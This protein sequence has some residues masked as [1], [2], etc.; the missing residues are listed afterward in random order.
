M[1]QRAPASLR[2]SEAV[3]PRCNG[4]DV[5]EEVGVGQRVAVDGSVDDKFTT[6]DLSMT[7][8]G[9][10]FI[11]EVVGRCSS[12]GYRVTKPR[13]PG[14]TGRLASPCLQQPGRVERRERRDLVERRGHIADEIGLRQR[15]HTEPALARD[16][17][18]RCVGSHDARPVVEVRRRITTSLQQNPRQLPRQCDRHLPWAGVRSS[19]RRARSRSREASRPT[20][21]ATSSFE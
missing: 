3:I 12:H 1:S 4:I 16:R 18:D 7:P 14:V 13:S 19:L 21:T 9:T 5:D 2:T 15:E 10:S 11:D 17:D 20:R 8:P 6:P